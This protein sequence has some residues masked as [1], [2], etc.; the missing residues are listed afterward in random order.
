MYKLYN[1]FMGMAL[2]ICVVAAA[3]CFMILPD[4]MTPDWELFLQTAYCASGVFFVAGS[5]IGI[6]CSVR[7]A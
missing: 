1:V 2:A 4:D 5:A 7:S 3:A 6:Y